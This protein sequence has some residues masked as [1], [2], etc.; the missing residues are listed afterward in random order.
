MELFTKDQI[1][2]L[3]ANGRA[4]TEAIEREGNTPDHVPVVKLF[5]PD[6]N[7]TWLISEIDPHRPD[8]AFG[9]ADLGMG[10]PELGSVS[11][12]ELGAIRGALGLP[13]ERDLHITLDQ[14]LSVYAEWARRHGHIVTCR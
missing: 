4:S 5:T 11:I 1:A 14:P 7:A 2:R 10:C 6:A 3:L 8:V 13:V 9:L 12:P